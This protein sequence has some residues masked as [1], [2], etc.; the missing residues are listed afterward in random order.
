MSFLGWVLSFV[1]LLAQT[2]D[3]SY[4][5]LKN[6]AEAAVAEKSFARAHTLYEQAQKV[7]PKD[8]QRWVAFRLA[9]TAWRGGTNEQEPNQAAREALEKVIRESPEHDR[10]WAEANE[11]LGD[12]HAWHSYQPYSE[13]YGAALDW[14]AGSSDLA[15]ARQ[16]YLDMVWRIVRGQSR[17]NPR[18]DE[19]PQAI[20]R[21][22][23][24]NAVAI[25]DT[26]ADRAHA[27]YLLAQQYLLHR[28]PDAVERA[29]ELLEQIVADGKKTAYYDDAL[30]LYASTLT[31]TGAVYVDEERAT[32]RPDFRRALELYR[33]ILTEFQPGQSKWVDDAKRAVEL[34][35]APSAGVDVGQTFLPDSEQQI[36][37]TWRNVQEVELTIAPTDL[38]RHSTKPEAWL[39]ETTEAPIRR[40]IEKTNDSGDHLPTH[41][42]VRITPRLATGAYVVTARGGGKTGRALLL[43]T[44]LHVLV[45]AVGGHVQA[46]VSH[47][48]TGEPVAGARVTVNR[49]RR[50][51]TF[52]QRTVE[53]N[54]SGIAD[55]GEFTQSNGSTLVAAAKGTRQ[56]YHSLHTWGGQRDTGDAWRIYAFTDRPAYRPGETVQWKLIARRRQQER[57]VTPEQQTLAYEIVNPRDEKV[58]EGKATLNAFGSFW[59]EL[60]L[61]DAM[62]L[63]TYTIRFKLGNDHV[64][65]AALFR[66]EEYKLP[67]FRVSVSTPEGKQ[68]RTGDVIEAEVEASY[69]FGG[70]VANATVEAVVWQ[71]PF[72]R[73]W[74]PWRQYPWYFEDQRVHQGGGQIVKRETVKTDAAGRAIIRIETPRDRGD[75]SYR[76]EAR[77][78]DASRREVTGKGEV[79]VTRQRYTVSMQPEHYLHRPGDRVSVAIKALDANDK[80]V[81][82]TGTV[83]VQRSEWKEKRY[84]VA[85]KVE[86]A[87]VTTDKDGE[88]TFTFTPRREGYYQ[89]EWASQ[90]VL[91]GETAR[92]GGVV[93][94]QTT[95]W[96][97]TTASTNIG[98]RSAGLE[99]IVDKEAFRAGTTAPVMIVTPAS[100]R[101]VVLT[102]SAY[103]I[104]ETQVLRLD[105]N[106]KL[107]QLALDQPHVPNFFLTASSVF[108]RTIATVTK[109]IVVPPVEQFVTVDV[110]PDR[111]Q[112]EPKQKGRVTVTARDADGKPVI[113]EVALAVSD[114]SVT[115]I[116][117]DLA[118]D[119][120]QF[121][122]G[123]RRYANLQASGSATTQQYVRLVEDDGVLY[124][125][126]YPKPVKQQE[127]EEERDADQAMEDGVV[128]S[129]AGNMAPPPPPMPVSAPA[130]QMSRR[131]SAVAESITVTAQAAPAAPSEVQATGAGADTNVQIEVRSDFRSTAFWKPDV[132]TDA[133]GTASVEVE[134]PQALTTWRATARAVTRESQF[135]IGTSTTRTNL[136]LIV[137]LQ[138]PRFFVAGD[139]VTV[140]AVINNNSDAAMQV[141]PSL[142]VE[143]LRLDA[144]AHVRVDVPAHGEARADW[145]VGA[146]KSGTAK[147]KVTGRSSTHGDAMEKT[148]VVYE[149]GIDK[150]VARSGKLRGEEAIVKLDLPRD[151]RATELLVRVQPSLAAAMFDALPYLLDFPYGCT[152]QTMSRFLPAAI[153]ARTLAQS[154]AELP[155][156]RKRLDEVTAASMARLYDFQ[157]HDGAWGWW[158]EGENDLWMTAY[159]VWGF[160]IARDGGLPVRKE[161]VDRAY[162]WLDDQLVE[163]AGSPHD[164]AWALHA[165]AAWRGTPSA[166]ARKA[167]D[168]A[169][170][171]RAELNAYSRA[172]L[173]L[174]AHDFGF[175]EQARVLVRNLEN[176]VKIDRTPDQSVL[177]RGETAAET[178]ATVHWGADRFWWR[179]WDSPVETT[180]F[181]LQAIVTIDPKNELIEPAMNWLVK[182]RRGA[183]WNN[184]RDTA[185]SILALNDYLKASGELTGDVKYE[186]TVNGTPVTTQS[187]DPSL[188]RD[189]NEIRI[190]RTGGRGP[191]YFAAEARFVSLE[192]PV[193]AAGHELFVRREYFRL[194]PRPTLL[195]GV[196]YDKVPLR[197]GESIKTGERL[198]VVATI[199]AKND[200]E[201]LLFEDLKPAGFEAIAL[202]SGEPLYATGPEGATAYVYQELRDRKVALFIDRL[203]QGMWEIRYPLRAEVPGSFHA[204]PLLGGPMYVPDVRANGDEMRV[205]VRE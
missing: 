178:M 7:A 104:L 144:P 171:R 191:I 143:G 73:Y 184:T 131:D 170:E 86:E 28:T 162:E 60:P 42:T 201:Y 110:K 35:T 83:I 112:Y 126:R 147:L 146:E 113:A 157:H 80:P 119:P 120:R 5:A 18:S 121:F 140:S 154:G 136:P 61:T 130:P 115:A 141:A 155:I 167:F 32:M 37:L 125:D 160:S 107:V 88:A 23:L 63:G 117:Q 74:M 1:S 14:W 98:Y 59:S 58:A 169:Y 127:Q 128:G 49:A 181:A 75:L 20:P 100:G 15:L 173:A 138:A 158:K 135:G 189:S 25:A 134:Y 57:W 16:R 198:E 34:I 152:E 203:G 196:V 199:D 10:V 101:W 54:A 45:H 38:T 30:H 122:F 168:A 97:S 187:I 3:G 6:Q 33:R 44:D 132:I 195:K 192:E 96:V 123:E 103:G 31:S 137:R 8:E 133:S 202:Q 153:V 72:Y 41:R 70:P 2:T 40:W 151:R 161:A 124:D 194:V 47:V 66:L 17:W 94:A 87:K 186:V 51:N 21:D 108:D 193:K 19:N 197:D 27:R 177:L 109:D 85:E 163:I 182:N 81:Q 188:I 92:A 129:A 29:Y 84:V 53:T 13:W 102:S 39:T 56:A 166:D 52:D 90:D 95:I 93:R 50:D 180:A 62:P 149:H 77:V 156:P 68:Y 11:S 67:E 145:T 114:E 139:R 22:V 183:R 176:G 69:Y 185:I 89:V 204:L 179:W 116:Q 55:A 64:G 79:R 78:V 91:P 118:G 111:E 71:E 200:Y 142:E 164:L 24:V 4:L 46:F 150:L 76:I 48:L 105:G 65:G 36:H 26:A 12:F 82:V 43:V 205:E 175:A 165:L 190:R 174:A 172:L 148:F 159:V 99:L 106:V 9:D